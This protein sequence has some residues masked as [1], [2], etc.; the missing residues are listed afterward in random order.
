MTSIIKLQ[1]LSGANDESPPSYLLQVDEFKFLLDCGWNEDY[2][3]EY[4]TELKRHLHQIDAVLLSY[5]D[6]Q[7]L[8]ALPYLVGKCGLTCPIYA[9]NP[10]Y[11]MG[12]MFMYDLYQSRHNTEDFNLFT[13]DDVDAAFDKIIQLKY[14]QSV[15][16]T[17]KGHGIQITPLPAGHMIGGTIWKIVKD[18][19][20]EIIYA[21]DYN[22][23]KERHL[24][25]CVLEMFN[26]PS[27]MITDAFNAS[28]N[29]ARR[30]LRDEQLMTTILQTMRNDGNVLVAVDTA[31]RMLEL[32]HLLDQM[33]RSAESGLSPYSLALLNNVSYNVV[34][35][36]KSQVEWMSDKIM[37]S[38]EENRNN[39]FQFKHVKLCHNLAEL[40]R[41]PE[42]KV[43][44]ASTPDLQCGF[45][46]DLFIAWCG[47]AKNSVILTNRTS[48]GTLARWLID[49]P[50][51]KTVTM[52]V[53]RRVKLEGAELEDFMTKKHQKE[54][55]EAKLKSEAKMDEDESSDESETEMEVDNI[56]APKTKGKHDLMMKSEGKSRTG[57]FKQAK[58]SHP[59]YPY[60]EEKIKWD[61]YGEFIKLEDFLILDMITGQEEEKKESEVT[62]TEDLQKDVME[63]PTKCISSNVTLDVNAS[64]LYID[65]EGRSDGDSIRKLLAQVKPRQLILVRGTTEATDALAEYCQTHSVVD[66]K[67]FTPKVGE[68]VDATTE[69]H[70]YQVRMRDHLVTSLIFSRAKD[71][72]LSW[73]DGYL[74][75][76][77]TKT[78]TSVMYESEEGDLTED[79]DK[80]KTKALQSTEIADELD[81]VPTLEA[82]PLNQVPVHTS[83]F[84]NE[85]KLS[86][87]KIVLLQE[88]IRCE[89][90]AGVLICNNTVAVRRNEAGRIQLEGTLCDDYYRIREILYQ[91]Y[92]IV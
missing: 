61:E 65:F 5:P 72:E 37:R 88:G 64:V 63:V 67:V 53:R 71:I 58:K 50:Q 78:D 8:G 10:V 56:F 13:L 44:L 75:M 59:M 12:Q 22:H 79:D 51:N 84:I 80:K 82:F 25:G 20:E 28:Y 74:D 9:T 6:Q 4:I 42:P 68:I 49:N 23:K 1:V 69:S 62:T 29:Q 7:H 83:V 54:A 73:I 76:S 87:F 3:M 41:V 14:S 60:H 55:K 48:P 52:E 40:S 21:V 17:G 77:Y 81:R 45:S 36:A 16:L 35:F 89:F 30:R 2:P 18:G 70:I 90:V 66:R 86:D 32:A 26:R 43:V 92:A 91:Q 33:W 39:P 46:R 57:F 47:I 38:F 15:T 27:L 11:K 19:E 24:N 31:G 85:P 34:E